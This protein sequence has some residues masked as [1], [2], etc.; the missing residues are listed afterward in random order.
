MS[1]KTNQV[2]TLLDVLYLCTDTMVKANSFARVDLKDS[3]AE[4]QAAIT[5]AVQRWPGFMNKG[6]VMAKGKEF[7]KFAES[8]PAREFCDATLASMCE[9]LVADIELE[10]RTDLKR[11][12]VAPLRPVYKKIHDFV[13]PEGLNYPAYDSSDK[14]LDELYRII[15]MG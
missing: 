10:A 4:A 9:R 11:E 3:L 15:G 5:R 13:D 12:L 8:V 7:R 6:W 14:M 1:R 2:I